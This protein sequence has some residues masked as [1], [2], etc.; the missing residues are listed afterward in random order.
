MRPKLKDSLFF[1]DKSFKWRISLVFGGL[2]FLTYLFA[3]LRH[4]GLP[5][6]ISTLLGMLGLYLLVT[7]E[8]LIISK[9]LTKQSY[10]N[11]GKL[12]KLIQDSSYTPILV[13]VKKPTT[14]ELLSSKTNGRCIRSAMDTKGKKYTVE[15]NKMLNSTFQANLYKIE[16]GSFLF[17]TLN[18]VV[19]ID[20]DVKENLA[21]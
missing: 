3:E 1:P 10:I 4:E 12:E 20:V 19:P 13:T 18:V 5:F 21:S 8:L 2:I 15:Y 9:I 17:F 16:K 7:L 6:N 14:V 11:L